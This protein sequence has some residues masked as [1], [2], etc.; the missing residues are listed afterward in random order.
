MGLTRAIVALSTRV[1]VLCNL[2]RRLLVDIYG[3]DE[4]KIIIIPHGVPDVP[5][6]YSLADAKKKLGFDPNAPIMTTFGLIHQNKN[7]QLALKAMQTVIKSVPNMMYLVIG[8][9]HPLIIKYIGEVYRHEL[10]GNVTALGLTNNVR[11]INKFVDNKEL[12]SYLAA[13]DIFLTPYAREDQYVSGTLSWA[14]GLGKVVISTP[15]LYAKELLAD[16]RGFLIPFNDDAFLSSIIVK[17][18]QNEE[19]R[20]EARQQAYKYGRRMA[21]PYVAKDFENLFR[22]ELLFH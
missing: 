7:I 4:S 10:E 14:V 2:G 13:S 3:I 5:F 22:E 12:L 16:G 8:Q 6:D 11:F 19:V 17:V 15:Y 21:W 1:V 20:N 9:T 18:L